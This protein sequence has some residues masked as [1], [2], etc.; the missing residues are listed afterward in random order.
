MVRLADGFDTGIHAAPD[1]PDRV[2]PHHLLHDLYKHAS[3]LSLPLHACTPVLC[4]HASILCQWCTGQGRG[5]R[6][7]SPGFISIGSFEA[8]TAL[9]VVSFESK[10]ERRDGCNDD[11]RDASHETPGVAQVHDRAMCSSTR[12]KCEEGAL[13]T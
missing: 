2:L 11:V 12:R 3:F 4:L 13:A 10:R 1:T 9:V 6:L 5:P 7:T 8:R